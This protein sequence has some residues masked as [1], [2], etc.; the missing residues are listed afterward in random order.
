MK[1]R[2][3]VMEICSVDLSLESGF[4]LAAL[5]VGWIESVDLMPTCVVAAPL[6]H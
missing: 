6:L 2:V 3:L 1:V 5:Q 4:W